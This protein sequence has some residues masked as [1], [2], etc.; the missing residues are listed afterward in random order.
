MKRFLLFAGSDYYPSGGWKDFQKDF[1][2]LE[3]ANNYI[4]QNYNADW[5]HLIDSKHME[6]VRET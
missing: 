2:T 1:D 6:V 4:G 3:E 5:F